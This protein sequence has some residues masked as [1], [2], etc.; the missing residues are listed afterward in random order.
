M[1]RIVCDSKAL[2]FI[3]FN[4][5]LYRFLKIYLIEV[6]VSMRQFRWNMAVKIMR[7]KYCNMYC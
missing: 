1:N 3:P 4:I 2:D 6:S 5:Y 7:L